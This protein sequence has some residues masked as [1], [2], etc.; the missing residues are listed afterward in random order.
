MKIKKE[1]ILRSVGAEN[2]VVAVGEQSRNFNGIIRLNETGKFLWEFLQVDVTEEFLADKL[3]DNYEIS[4]EQAMADV[5]R[6]TER[7][8][9]AGVLA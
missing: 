7:L 8:K 9:E 5:K 2:V 1:F 3:T 6:F 4:K